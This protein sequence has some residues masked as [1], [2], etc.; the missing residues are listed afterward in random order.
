MPHESGLSVEIQVPRREEY[1]YPL[2]QFRPHTPF[3]QVGVPLGSVLH[4][5]DVTPHEVIELESE[6]VLLEAEYV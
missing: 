3:V 5:E 4:I 6:Q 1:E 2:L